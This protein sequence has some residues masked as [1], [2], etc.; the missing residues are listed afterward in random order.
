M[1]LIPELRVALEN[2]PL[3]LRSLP[4]FASRRWRLRVLLTGGSS[5]LAAALAALILILS[6]SSSTPPA[7]ALTRHADG[8]VTLRLY[9]LSRGIPQLNA[10]LASLGI[11]ETVVPIRK[12]CKYGAPIYPQA[13]HDTIT[14][15][16]HHYDLASGYQGFLAAERLANGRVAY[17]QGALRPSEIPPCFAPPAR[18]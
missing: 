8:T 12:G 11:S 3:R 10:K 7:Y 14:L 5:A 6:A 15:R 2:V 16:P 17:G 1:T 9:D 13:A 18:Y 4:R